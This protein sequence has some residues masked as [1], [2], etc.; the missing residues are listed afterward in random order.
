MKAK[1]LVNELK[2]QVGSGKNVVVIVVKDKKRKKRRRR[3]FVREV[4]KAARDF[5]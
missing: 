2:D 4:A 5:V 3:T 1:Q